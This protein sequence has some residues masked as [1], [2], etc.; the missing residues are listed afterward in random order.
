MG[1]KELMIS[2]LVTLHLFT[3]LFIPTILTRLAIGFRPVTTIHLPKSQIPYPVIFAYRISASKGDLAKL[4][5]ALQ[6][7]YHPGNYYLF[8]VDHNAMTTEHLELIQFVSSNPVFAE[9]GNV[10][11]VQKSNLVTYRGPTMLATTLHAMAM[12]QRTCNWDWFI[13]LS[14][15]DYPLITQDDLIH[16]F[17]DLPK[18][19]NFIQHN[20]HLGC[21]KMN[22]RGKPIIID[23]GLYSHNKSEIRRVIKQRALPT[24]FKL[25]T[26]SAWTF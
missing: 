8:H 9:M 21:W 14:A 15:S 22:K 17:S 3:L 26:G 1:I 18:D 19:L 10:W 16:A 24:A 4:K 25:Y 20:N 13:N 6:A 23:P 11:V 2:F 12:L 5:H 7:F